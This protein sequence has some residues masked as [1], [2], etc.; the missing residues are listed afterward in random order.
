MMLQLGAAAASPSE[1]LVSTRPATAEDGGQIWKLVKES[2]A[3]DQNSPYSYLLLCR[4]FSSTCL[5]AEAE[6]EIVGFVTA[7]KPPSREDTIFVWQVGVKRSQRGRGIAGI[8]LED[9]L[10]QPA[11]EDV[12]WLEATVTPSNRP[13]RNLFRSLAERLEAD[14]EVRPYLGPRHFPGNDHEAEELFRIGPLS[15]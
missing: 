11:C 10:V 14:C 13:S 9:L 6:D 12:S 2:G 15:E 5:V 7:F 3:L 1:D 8:L 4:E